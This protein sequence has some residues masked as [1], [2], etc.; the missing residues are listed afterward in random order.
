[1]EFGQCTSLNCQ[2]RLDDEAWLFASRKF[3][4]ISRRTGRN[5]LASESERREMGDQVGVQIDGW[6][7]GRVCSVAFHPV[8]LAKVIDGPVGQWGAEGQGGLDRDQSIIWSFELRECS[9]GSCEWPADGFRRGSARY[10]ETR[11]AGRR[12]VPSVESPGGLARDIQAPLGVHS[13]RI[14]EPENAADSQLGKVSQGRSQVRRSDGREA[15]D[16]PLPCTVCQQP[17]RVEAAHAVA[18][19]MDGLVW[20]RL[21]DLLTQAVGPLLDAGDRR[22][23]CHEHPISGRDETLGYE[24]K[25]RREREAANADS[26]KAEQAVRQHDGRIKACDLDSGQHRRCGVDD[27]FP[28]CAGGKP[29]RGGWDRESRWSIAETIRDPHDILQVGRPSWNWRASFCHSTLR[30]VPLFP[31]EAG[32]GYADQRDC[33]DCDA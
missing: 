27:S 21:E 13:K 22:H 14:H 10:R 15:Q 18:D 33:A 25:V 2:T 8:H 7:E 24:P 16:P 28:A 1:M 11:H 23:S 5:R 3:L 12:R 19:Q 6:C 32:A 26:R 30:E 29:E 17:S 4:E 20:K 31:T 9:E